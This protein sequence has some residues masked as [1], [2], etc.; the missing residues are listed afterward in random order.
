[1]KCTESFS[2]YSFSFIKEHFC[3]LI[4]N[5]GHIKTIFFLNINIKIGNK[6][7]LKIEEE[8]MKSGMELKR[9]LV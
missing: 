6:K 8:K 1:M 5:N 4:T 3:L 2:K 7:I 9:F